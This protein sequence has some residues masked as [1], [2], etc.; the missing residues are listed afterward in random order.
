M[1]ALLGVALAVACRCRQSLPRSIDRHTESGGGEY[2]LV[3]LSNGTSDGVEYK[4][5]VTYGVGRCAPHDQALDPRCAAD[6]VPLPDAPTWCAKCIFRKKKFNAF[7][8]NFAN[9]WRARS[10]LYQNEILQENMRLTAFFK[11]Y[12][13]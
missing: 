6:A 8:E 1:R 2:V 4:A 5:P 13:I 9:Y 10:R 3:R 12:E 7:F 11:L